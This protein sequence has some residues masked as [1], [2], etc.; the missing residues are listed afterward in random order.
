MQ[1]AYFRTAW[2]DIKDSPGWFGKLVT[3]ALVGLIP[4]FGWIVIL[5][6][7][8]GWAREMAWGV[9]EPLP[10]RIFGNKEGG[11]YS[12]G[13]YALVIVFV[14]TLVPSLLEGLLSAVLNVTAIGAGI[15]GATLA[16]LLLMVAGLHAAL[17]LVIFLFSLFI[18]LFQWVGTM[19]MSIYGRLSAGFQLRK[20]WSMIKHDW[21]GLLRILGMAVL[22]TLVALVVVAA[23]AAVAI[24]I[25]GL[26]FFISNGFEVSSISE[27][28]N[29]ETFKGRFGMVA[30]VLIVLIAAGFV[31]MA[32]ITFIE[33]MVARAM[34]YWTM[35]FD[36]ANWRGQ[37]DPMPFETEGRYGGGR[38]AGGAYGGG[39][40]G[41]S[42]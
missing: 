8:Y 35:Q 18:E 40:G 20:I 12:R 6:Y 9:H 34:G 10:E 26:G 22:M 15:G 42:W 2:R 31:I 28:L 36:V 7:V 27:I 1:I 25:L 16:P 21:R 29:I 37:D 39:W 24:V 3:L 30:L 19:R 14:C 23:I 32:M 17:S 38:G 5:G 4:I 11:L 41:S 33:M 13:L